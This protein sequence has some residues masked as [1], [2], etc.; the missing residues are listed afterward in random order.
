MEDESSSLN[1]DNSLVGLDLSVDLS[2]STAT[3][4]S[5][6]NDNLLGSLASAGSLLPSLNSEL[7]DLGF[8]SGGTSLGLQGSDS[9]LSDS[10]FPLSDSGRR[11]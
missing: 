5:A 1:L 11:A 4:A 3:A 2:N 10:E 8:S 7:D 6:S 9:L